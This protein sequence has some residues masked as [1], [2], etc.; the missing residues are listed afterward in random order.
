M[1]TSHP[2]QTDDV[3]V[4][5]IHALS[6]DPSLSSTAVKE[7][8]KGSKLSKDNLNELRAIWD[9]DHV[10]PDIEWRKAWAESHGLKG[11]ANVTGFFSRKQKQG[12]RLNAEQLPASTSVPNTADGSS[13]PVLMREMSTA[14]H[15]PA[16]PV[17]SVLQQPV[18]AAVASPGTVAMDA[19]DELR[20]P[21]HTPIQE[22]GTPRADTP[23]HAPI[24]PS[25]DS[26]SET[27]GLQ[28]YTDVPS[29]LLAQAYG[30]SPV[31]DVPFNDADFR[32]HPSLP[33]LS[34][35]PAD[36]PTAL[37]HEEATPSV[38]SVPLYF[39]DDEYMR[40]SAYMESESSAAALDDDASWMKMEDA[41][42][43]DHT[44]SNFSSISSLHLYDDSP[45]QSDDVTRR[46]SLSI[47]QTIYDDSALG[48][49]DLPNLS[50][51]P[52]DVDAEQILGD[53]SVTATFFNQHDSPSSS[54]DDDRI[55]PELDLPLNEQA[56]DIAPSAPSS[57]ES[58]TG[59]YA[60]QTASQLA[61]VEEDIASRTHDDYYWNELVDTSY[62]I[63][64]NLGL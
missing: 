46:R 13:S 32:T 7:T 19:D 23:Y 34:Y 8:P 14:N 5:Y 49:L 57:Y 27:R 35:S 9:R 2:T 61:T 29:V 51:E 33:S 12:A 44:I 58:M 47:P 3:L 28:L 55:E 53:P 42:L 21:F 4:P 1:A 62:R 26:T 45:M 63:N 59:P 64:Q 15:G 48:F 60:Y 37:T 17:L 52:W 18:T 56:D 25:S 24:D 54:C 43:V 39:A 6:P 36:S 11:F 10:M 16:R 30:I 40:M 20:S 41:E 22:P 31:S 50:F 38:L